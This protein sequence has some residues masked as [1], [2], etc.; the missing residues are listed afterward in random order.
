MSCKNCKKDKCIVDI[1]RSC[2]FCADH[3]DETKITV[4]D[5][6][7]KLNSYNWLENY[8]ANKPEDIF[9]VRF[10][11]TRKG[12]FKNVNDLELK[13]GDVVA[14]EASPGYDVGI[15]SLT[16]DLIYSQ[17][18]KTGFN[19]ANADFKKI[20][21]KVKQPDIEKWQEAIALEH[22][23]MIQ[24]RQIAADLKLNMKIGDVEYQGDR[25]KAIFYYIADERVD[26]RELIKIFADRFKIRIEMRQIGARQEAGRIG[27]IG[28]CG[29]ELC[30]ASWMSNFVSVTTNSARTQEISLNPQK[31]AGQCGKLKCCLVY[32]LDTYIDARKALPRINAPLEVMDAN[33]YL[34]K[35]DILSGMMS[36]STEPNSMAGMVSIPAERAWEIIRLNKK[37]KKPDTLMGD[38]ADTQSEGDEPDFRSAVGEDSITR[39]DKTKKRKPKRRPEGNGSDSNGSS[40]K[41]SNVNG[42][43]GN[44][45]GGNNRR[46]GSD[47][48]GNGNRRE[49]KASGNGESRSAA[50]NGNGENGNRNPQPRRNNNKYRNRKPKNE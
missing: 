5:G 31:L 29:R 28:S 1:G 2:C 9:E 40:A 36:F 49:S 39:F 26:F 12:Y 38:Y 4:C 44:G 32:E 23:T 46:A 10:K 17:M 20:Y 6:G 3:G 41:G 7:S 30:C 48:G 43:G 8:P 42:R 22:T 33:Y 34:V 24:S 35:S 16:G 25:T 47:N 45:N 11:N 27:G 13:M 18:K 37:G 19:I 50:E 14:V 15:I 21:R